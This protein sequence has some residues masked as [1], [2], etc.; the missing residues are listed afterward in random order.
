MAL[1]LKCA[2]EQ[3]VFVN[4]VAA[5]EVTIRER[6]IV[7]FHLPSTVRFDKNVAAVIFPPTY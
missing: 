6:S 7:L 3:V 1:L 2:I 5:V 4:V